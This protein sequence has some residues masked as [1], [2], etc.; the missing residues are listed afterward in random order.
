MNAP[1]IPTCPLGL[2]DGDLSAWRDHALAPADERRITA[3]TSACPACQRVIASHEALAAALR[4]EQPPAPDP[5]NWAR[6]QERIVSARPA[7]R[8][9]AQLSAPRWRRAAVWSG[10]GAAVAALVISALFFSLF[11]QMIVLRGGATA[12][13]GTVA[14]TSP[15]MGPKLTWQYRSIPASVTP[16]PGSQSDVSNIFFAPTD[17]QTAYIC[18]IHNALRNAPVAIW[19]THDGARTWT[20]V[21][22]LPNTTATTGCMVTVDAHDPLRLNVVVHGQN[23]YGQNPTTYVDVVSSY[24][25]EN[26][27]KTWR[28]ISAAPALNFLATSGETS[29]AIVD[30][31]SDFHG[32]PDHSDPRLSISHDG[33]RT[34]QP[35]D[36]GLYT[37]LHQ[38]VIRVWQRPGNGALLALVMTF[39]V[40]SQSSG[41]AT[42]SVT[43][44]GSTTPTA[45]SASFSLWSSDD[46]GAH[47]TPFPTPTNLAGPSAYF[48]VAQPYGTAPWQV[49]GVA[50]ASQSAAP[51]STSV[52]HT[53]IMGC[54]R[55]SGRTWVSRPLPTL[56]ESCGAGCLPQRTLSYTSALLPDGSLVATF[57]AV[58]T[59]E[60]TA[61]AS[62][63]PHIFRLAA[64]SDQ[65]QDL[66]SQ[67]ANLL[68]TL[69]SGSGGAL[70]SF[71]GEIYI[72]GQAYYGGVSGRIVGQPGGD[73]PNRGVLAIATLP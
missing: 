14:P 66:G 60:K 10:L 5:L 2:T 38:A 19:A 6:L 4:A 20:H 34:W 68:L 39:T 56:N 67:P 63:L 71:S 30:P 21:S 47:W 33:F 12:P 11:G 49:C 73:I 59:G 61:Q 58:S 51:A 70:V 46:L 64:G 52:R 3:H 37:L 40:T 28:T 53:Q 50:D 57:N 23:V 15:I 26:G 8:F 25:S 42:A 55:D 17:H 35:I 24:I 65:W 32:S 69:S 9:V 48:F 62:G 43:P 44:G 18:F 41:K 16:P 72:E 27:G 22:D 45:G 7:T 36:G 54:T 1:T 31:L 29:V 13:L